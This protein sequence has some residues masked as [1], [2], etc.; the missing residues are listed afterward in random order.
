MFIDLPLT[1]KNHLSSFKTA[2]NIM[3]AFCNCLSVNLNYLL[4]HCLALHNVLQKHIEAAVYHVYSVKQVLFDIQ[5]QFHAFM[6]FIDS[7]HVIIN[8]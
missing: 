1:F 2:L 6:R 8:S 7:I 3:N 5:F 4:M